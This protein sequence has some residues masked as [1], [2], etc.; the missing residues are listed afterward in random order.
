[1]APKLGWSG[2]DGARKR[3]GKDWLGVMNNLS[4]RNPFKLGEYSTTG[5][6]RQAIADI[7]Q[8]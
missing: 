4:V 5:I 1:V 6:V 2:G 7:K 8:R 3:N